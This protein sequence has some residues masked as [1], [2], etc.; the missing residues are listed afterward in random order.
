MHHPG[1][2]DLDDPS[3]L[4]PS[5]RPPDLPPPMAMLPSNRRMPSYEDDLRKFYFSLTVVISYK[6]THIF[7]FYRVSTVVFIYAWSRH[8][9]R[10]PNLIS[11]WLSPTSITLLAT[12]ADTWA[13]PVVRKPVNANP[14][15][16]F[17]QGPCFSYIK[18][19]FAGNSKWPLESNQ[20]QNVAQKR[21]TGIC[22]AWL[23]NGIENCR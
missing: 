22:I 21:L 8:D 20:S 15:L 18:R 4:P 23:Q 1:D 11:K 19:V 10:R 9:K 17:I 16:K 12:L 6:C 7:R 14:G 5:E 2:L 13:G 3:T